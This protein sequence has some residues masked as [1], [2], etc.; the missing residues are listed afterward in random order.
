MNFPIKYT[1][2]FLLISI[3][4]FGQHQGPINWLTLEEA[5][6][7]YQIEKKPMFIDVY[8]SWCG[9]CKKMDAS[10][11]QDPT[12]A[13]YLNRN[14]YAVKLDAEM[15]DSVTFNGKAYGNSQALKAKEMV[16]DFELSID[17]L[18]NIKDI[19]TNNATAK[20]DSLQKII[21]THKTILSKV[22]PLEKSMIQQE[23]LINQ[24]DTATNKKELTSQIKALKKQIKKT[25]KLLAKDSILTANSVHVKKANL[26]TVSTLIIETQK[27]LSLEEKNQGE[28]SLS[29]KEEYQKTQAEISGRQQQLKSFQRRSR[30]TTHD[31]AIDLCRGNMSYPTFIILFNELA[32]NMPLKGFQQ[33]D[34]LLSYLAFI[35]EGVYNSTRNAGTYNQLF[36]K[37]I[38]PEKDQLPELI[39][40]KTFEQA[41]SASKK[42]GK[43]I[44]IHIT[45]K[46]SISSLIMD[47]T[48]YRDPKTAKMINKNFHAV[49]LS[50]TETREIMYKGQKL[51]NI[52]GIHQLAFAL[53]QQNIAFPTHSFLDSNGDLIMRV[54]QFFEPGTMIPVLE[55]FIAEGYRVGTFTDWNNSQEIQKN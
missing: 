31:V 40:W 51:K 35:H 3:F 47:K 1:L 45:D 14:F 13:A 46:G 9:W 29:A 16:A 49:K 37:S 10:T 43:K 17:S 48:S 15:Q 2:G 19:K 12:V 26:S 44:L 36:K 27:K 21:N 8:T 7:L 6:S 38:L 53:M 11:F 20:I 55:Y 30:K 33:P 54:P 23:S 42:D 39:K 18:L 22:Q 4:S 32:A 41:L 24:V 52:G 50:A 5:D 34:D 25:R 28:L